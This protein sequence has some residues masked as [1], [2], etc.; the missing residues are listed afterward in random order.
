MWTPEKC[1]HLDL[2]QKSSFSH[3]QVCLDWVYILRC[4][5]CKCTC[6]S[7]DKN[8]FV[9][10]IRGRLHLSHNCTSLDDILVSEYNLK[11]HFLRYFN[12]YL[13]FE[14]CL[15]TTGICSL[16]IWSQFIGPWHH[17]L[18]NSIKDFPGYNFIFFRTCNAASMAVTK[19]ELGGWMFNEQ[20]CMCFVKWLHLLHCILSNDS[21]VGKS[22]EGRMPAFKVFLLH[23]GHCDS[24]SFFPLKIH[25]VKQFNHILTLLLAFPISVLL[26]S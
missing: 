11:V 22:D 25:A 4:I 17:K 8:Y 14:L 12:M 7:L 26:T 19:S 21:R 20:F 5:I 13:F 24:S 10:V 15:L 2:F 23:A 1:E 16:W 9:E 18:I 3:P 6:N